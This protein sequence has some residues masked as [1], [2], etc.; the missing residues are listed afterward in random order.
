MKACLEVVCGI[1]TNGDGE[2]LMALRHAHQ[3]QGGLWEFPGGKIDGGETTEQALSRE[4]AEE[5]GIEVVAASAWLQVAHAYPDYCVNLN[6]WRVSQYQGE[7][8]GAEGQIIRW[9]PAAELKT[10]SIPAANHTVISLLGR[11]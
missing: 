1:I 2:Y 4:L 11:P 9:V 5:I 3:D 7:P 8:V 10:L 6:V